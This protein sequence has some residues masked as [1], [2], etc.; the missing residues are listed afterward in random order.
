MKITF[1]KIN[2]AFKIVYIIQ[3]R[4][5]ERERERKLKRKTHE[6]N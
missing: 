6:I 2:R 5:R 3:E 4:E 1:F